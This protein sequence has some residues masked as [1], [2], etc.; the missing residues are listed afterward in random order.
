LEAVGEPTDHALQR[1]QLLI[2][3]SAEACELIRIAEVFGRDL[4]V[5]GAGEDLVMEAGI[6]RDVWKL[7]PEGLRAGFFDF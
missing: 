2:E 5:V 7:R 3:I 4:F 6:V 1:F